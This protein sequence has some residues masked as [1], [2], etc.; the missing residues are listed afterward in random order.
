LAVQL[1][2]RLNDEPT[3]LSVAGQIEQAQPFPSLIA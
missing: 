2:G 1:V 3:L